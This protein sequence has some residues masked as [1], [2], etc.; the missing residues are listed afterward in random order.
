MPPVEGT[1]E[2]G[3]PQRR[4]L[5]TSCEHIIHAVMDLRVGGLLNSRCGE[6]LSTHAARPVA[7]ALISA[8][9]SPFT[10]DAGHVVCVTI[11]AHRMTMEGVRMSLMRLPRTIAG[12]YV[13]GTSMVAIIAAGCGTFTL[14]GL[15]GSGD[16]VGTFVN[17]NK[18]TDL[19]GGVRLKSGEAVFSFGHWLSDGS[20]GEVSS[21]VYHNRE[22]QDST[23]YL[24]SGRPSR[25]LGADGSRLEILYQEV[26]AQRLKGEVTLT[27]AGQ[28]PQ[29][30]PFDIDLQKTAQEV[31]ALIQQLTGI[32]VS[33]AAPPDSG[34]TTVTSKPAETD[35][36]A[37]A[38]HLAVLVPVIFVVTGFTL[39]LILGQ[40]LNAIL[41]TADA[42]VKSVTVAILTPFI[43]MGNL[44]HWR[45]GSR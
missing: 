43:L 20:V 29:I 27:P 10:S 4:V 2:G 21:I 12:R 41:I 32:Q 23:L 8:Q 24:D 36:A 37:G 16:I 5:A 9:R 39:N 1:L 42:L 11:R 13:S 30:Y 22:G 7:P 33:T 19:I 40:L 3:H 25:L 35:K 6:E 18:S 45:W 17:G 14:P 28:S 38:A 15:G 26:S 34:T 44:M 31:S